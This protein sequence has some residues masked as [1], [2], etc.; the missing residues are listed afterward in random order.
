MQKLLIILSFLGLFFIIS[1]TEEP[2]VSNDVFWGSEYYPLETGHTLTYKI[3]EIYIDKPSN[4]YDTLIYYVKE[5]VDIPFIDNE[6][7]TAYRI[8]RYRRISENDNWLIH[9]VWT[10]KLTKNTAEKVEENY[11]FIKIRFPL[12]QNYSWNGNL[13]NE[14]DNKEYWVSNFNIPY[15]TGEFVFDSCLTIFQ[16]SSQSLIHKDIAYEVYAIHTGLIYKEETYI[17]SQEV[18]FE[19]PVEERITTGTIF[20]QEL[21]EF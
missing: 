11:R 14:L 3:T 9:S 7:D 18:I 6:N 19:I 12:K 4:V 20:K 10:T 13:Y 5:V 1:C 21:V 8:E 16:D 2:S 15:S 17:N